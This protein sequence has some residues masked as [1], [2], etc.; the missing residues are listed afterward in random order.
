MNGKEKTFLFAGTMRP[1]CWVDV[2]LHVGGQ[3]QRQKCSDDLLIEE[4]KKYKRKV[5]RA[6]R[7]SVGHLNKLLSEEMD[8]V[9]YGH[10][11]VRLRS[12]QIQTLDLFVIFL[13]SAKV[14]ASSWTACFCLFFSESFSW[15]YKAHH[16]C[17]SFIT[18]CSIFS[19]ISR[20]SIVH[21]LP[22]YTIFW[23]YFIFFSNL[24]L[25]VCLS[26]IYL[27]TLILINIFQYCF[28]NN[29]LFI[30]FHFPR[31]RLK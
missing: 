5:A 29:S 11:V 25:F 12:A 27:L 26:H 31:Q 15:I 21:A 23:S 1:G 14:L 19:S 2:G 24:L 18:L 7:A 22:S 8:K 6:M 30:C 28:I 3:Q 20:H 17:C 4:Q 10:C 13:L 9:R 16:H